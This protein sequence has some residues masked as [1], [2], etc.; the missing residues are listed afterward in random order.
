[1]TSTQVEA[2]Q[3]TPY[4]PWPTVKGFIEELKVTVVPTHIDTSV[5]MKMSGAT[6][7]QVRGALRYWNCIDEDG[8]V[9]PELRKLVET[10]GTPD[11]KA[12]LL[13]VVS[14]AYGETLDGLDLKTATLKQLVERFRTYGNVSGHA[15]RKAVRFFLATLGETGVALS[16]HLKARGLRSLTT[17]ADRPTRT[18][19][20]PVGIATESDTAM[21]MAALSRGFMP[22]KADEF[23]IQLPGR[24]APLVFPLP[25]DLSDAEWNYIVQQIAAFRALRADAKK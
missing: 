19:V 7:S 10:F 25:A 4:P 11:W 14:T 2:K 13:D 21:S 5:M 17:P 16:P 20:V 8:A 24:A 18:K 12:T 6:R 1:M 9:R 15:L 23:L 22:P 3:T